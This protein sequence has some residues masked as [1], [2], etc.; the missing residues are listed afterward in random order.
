MSNVDYT[1]ILKK[2]TQEL[3]QE[4]E[5]WAAEAFEAKLGEDYFQ[6]LGMAQG[7]DK[8]MQIVAQYMSEVKA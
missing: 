5:R 3:E 4:S 1:F 6:M 2:I 7:L 8:A